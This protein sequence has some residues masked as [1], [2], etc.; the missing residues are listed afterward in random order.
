MTKLPF[1]I[2]KIVWISLLIR[3]I[4]GQWLY[5]VYP[6][7]PF[8]PDRQ[9][10]NN[11][12]IDMKS[13]SEPNVSK[14][15]VDLISSK[16][17]LTIKPRLNPNNAMF[18]TN[19][20]GEWT[21]NFLNQA[22]P[23]FPLLKVLRPP[24]SNLLMHL[25]FSRPSA[26]FVR[27]TIVAFSN[28]T[29]NNANKQQVTSSYQPLPQP[30]TLQR[31]WSMPF[32]SVW[33]S[34]SLENTLRPLCRC[35]G[36][37]HNRAIVCQSTNSPKLLQRTLLSAAILLQ[38]EGTTQLDQL[39]LFNCSLL[40]A[41]T[42]DLALPPTLSF[43]SIHFHKTQ[44]RSISPHLQFLLHNTDRL[45]SLSFAHNELQT[46]PFR[47]ACNRL[48]HL[49]RLVLRYNHVHSIPEHALQNC[50]SL[51][52]LDLSF[53][54]L[55]HVGA[56]AFADASSLKVLKM[57]ANQL[58]VVNN[59]AFASA[60][61]TSTSPYLSALL[62]SKHLEQLTVKSVL[63]N[64][65]IP[66][67]LA[68]R[69]K[70]PWLT[71]QPSHFISEKQQ[72]HLLD[73]SANQIQHI[74]DGA[75]DLLRTKI[76]DLSENHLKRLEQ[77]HFAVILE[78]MHEME[79]ENGFSRKLNVE[80]QQIV[81]Q[82]QLNALQQLAIG[83]TELLS[84]SGTLNGTQTRL[85]TKLRPLMLPQEFKSLSENASRFESEFDRNIKR[86]QNGATVS[87]SWIK[88]TDGAHTVDSDNSVVFFDDEELN[89][90]DWNQFR[91]GRQIEPKRVDFE[92][93]PDS[94][95]HL[96]VAGEYPNS[97]SFCLL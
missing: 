92:E 51:E 55:L 3:T 11:H 36:Q 48:P 27:P 67:T 57:R 2:P 59:F 5:P 35:A 62:V 70:V 85:K 1:K 53:N 25:L 4:A 46:F 37:S 80:I 20:N 45:R 34:S 68:N 49:Q 47:S 29:I 54:R 28:A 40:T 87:Q 32:K 86:L 61:R 8:D 23:T 19:P 16:N 12:S 56:Y 96:N 6:F 97:V 75:F 42:L 79:E 93:L 26:S 84:E 24:P 52:Y 39:Q 15:D 21:G 82:I 74:A 64:R 72:M 38:N 91:D 22:N 63:Q 9:T 66:M 10:V 44:L 95:A 14:S 89:D 13:I 31:G 60:D 43:R 18:H 71:G 83:Q 94:I 73:L 69:T 30:S 7:K 17:K 77:K 33:C 78:Q 41:A 65:P 50:A 90:P 88:P 76:L 58:K 81:N